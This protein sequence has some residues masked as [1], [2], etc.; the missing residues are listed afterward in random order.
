M[1]TD[2]GSIHGFAHGRAAVPTLPPADQ[3]P[4]TAA[5]HRALQRELEKL[6][7]EKAQFAAQLRLAHEFGDTSNN[8][9]YLAIREEEMVVDARL[10]RL[11]DILNRARIV[12]PAGSDGRVAIGCAVTVLDRG[13]GE[14]VDYVIDSAHAP[15]A[16]N[17]VSAVS[18]VGRALLGR[19]TGDLV[20]V[21][22]PRKGRTREL[23]ILAVTPL[24]TP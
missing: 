10:G 14:P 21:E 17:A 11:E 7:Q 13:V 6:R 24:S 22:L 8:D 2:N 4:V 23:E 3:L 20:S 5:A 12:D 1:F 19:S 9:E 18:P 16:P 15:V